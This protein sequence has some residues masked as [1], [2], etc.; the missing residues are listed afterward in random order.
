MEGDIQCLRCYND[1]QISYKAAYWS[2]ECDYLRPLNGPQSVLDN[3][4]NKILVSPNPFDSYFRINIGMPIE[5]ALYDSFGK[6]L[7]QGKEKE[8]N[9]TSLSKGIYLLRLTIDNKEVKTIKLVK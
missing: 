1:A 6:L 2:K 7:K 3:L 4:D 9:T 5:Y 8:V